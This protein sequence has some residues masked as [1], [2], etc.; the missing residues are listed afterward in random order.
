MG[1]LLDTHIVLWLASSPDKIDPSVK[2]I[3]ENIDSDIYFSAVNFWEIAIK[4]QLDKRDFQVDSV[5][6]YKQMLEHSFIELPVLSK[7]TLLLESLPNH[8]KDPFDRLLIAQSLDENLT[9][10]THDASI[11]KYDLSVKKA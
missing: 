10:I 3:L 11:W 5:K 8:H 7:H 9:L 2:S 4:N 1:Y 6:L